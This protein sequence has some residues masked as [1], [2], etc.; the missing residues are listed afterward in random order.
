MATIHSHGMHPRHSLRQN[1]S[2]IVVADVT[3]YS[4]VVLVDING[5]AILNLHRVPQ[6]VTV[7]DVK[8]KISERLKD[9]GRILPADLM[10]AYVIKEDKGGLYLIGALYCFIKR[11]FSFLFIYVFLRILKFGEHAELDMENT[12][13]LNFYNKMG[14]SRIQVQIS[15]RQKFDMNVVVVKR[16]R[17][18]L[19][20]NTHG[21][22]EGP[23]W[24]PP[25]GAL[26]SLSRG[27]LGAPPEGPLGDVMGA[28]KRA[29]RR[30]LRGPL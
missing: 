23:F 14:L 3:D 16:K 13:P 28:S 24:R 6:H 4:T 7:M 19:T 22:P 11:W 21:A 9:V 25:L 5:R 29:L 18:L 20:P 12:K 10:Y 8:N 1:S 17:P 15:K 2:R 30:P 27:S 26:G